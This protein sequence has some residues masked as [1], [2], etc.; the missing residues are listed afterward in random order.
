MRPRI[1]S[2]AGVMSL[3]LLITG[4]GWG[5]NGAPVGTPNPPRDVMDEQKASFAKLDDEDRILAQAQGY[6]VVTAEALGSMGTP[7]KLIVNEQPV[8]V[9]CKGCERK[10]RSNP[11]Q[12]LVKVAK[13]KAKV[14]SERPH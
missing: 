14:K 8:F 9:C 10:A 3:A 4:C 12:T 11:D 6:C 2:V 1:L 13:L 7:I 5:Q